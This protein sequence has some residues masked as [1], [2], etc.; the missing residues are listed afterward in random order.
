[1]NKRFYYANTWFTLPIKANGYW[2]EDADRK[3]IAE[4]ANDEMAKALAQTLNF[5][6]EVQIA[7]RAVSK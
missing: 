1:M 3:N 5:A 7:A 2:V 4:A 6:A